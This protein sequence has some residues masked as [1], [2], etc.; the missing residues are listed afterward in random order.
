MGSVVHGQASSATTESVSL[1]SVLAAVAVLAEQHR[2]VL[3]AVCGIQ[4]LVAHAALEAGLVEFV[5]TGNALLS[6]VHG[7]A[8]LG[9]L[10]GLNSDERHFGLWLVCDRDRRA[11]N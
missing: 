10:G 1:R 5:S 9:A 2:L 6:S 11:N 7:L 4:S 3:T 8:A